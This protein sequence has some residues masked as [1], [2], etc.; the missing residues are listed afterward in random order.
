MLLSAFAALVLTVHPFSPLATDSTPVAR[1]TSFGVA[2]APVS[3]KMRALPYLEAD[4]GVVLTE[5]RAGSAAAAAALKAG[6]IVLAVDGKRVDETT[7]FSAI[8]ERPRNQAFRVEYLRAGKWK[9]T[10][11]TIDG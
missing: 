6:D 10:W 7:L 11:V 2:I 5:V 8:R 9:E 1:H 4:E 3:E